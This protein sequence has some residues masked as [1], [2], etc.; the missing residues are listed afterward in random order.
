MATPAF[1]AAFER[2]IAVTAIDGNDRPY[3]RANRGGYIDFAEHGVNITVPT[4][5]DDLVVSGTS[6]ASPLVAARIAAQL[7]APSVERARAILAD[8]RARALDLGDPGHD[9]IFGWGAV[10]N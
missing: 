10:R 6:F 1:P 3:V 2:S 7:Q 5:G 8:L 9:V 4:G